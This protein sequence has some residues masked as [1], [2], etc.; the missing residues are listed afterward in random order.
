MSTCYYLFNDAP[1]APAYAQSDGSITN[2]SV[3]EAI[4]DYIDD[5]HPRDRD[6]VLAMDALY[7]NGCTLQDGTELI[8]VGATEDSPGTVRAQAVVSHRYDE[9]VDVTLEFTV[10]GG[11]QQQVTERIGDT[12]AR[13]SVYYD[14]GGGTFEVCCGIVDVTP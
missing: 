4:E 2:A 14:T 9:P 11:N 1:F 10:D 6:D 5:D 3:Q 7:E 13:V 12:P 8:D